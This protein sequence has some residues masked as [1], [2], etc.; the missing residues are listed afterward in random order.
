MDLSLSRSPLFNLQHYFSQKKYTH[1]D[2]ATTFGFQFKRSSNGSSF[3]CP[4]LSYGVRANSAQISGQSKKTAVAPSNKTGGLSG[5][6]QKY[7]AKQVTKTDNRRNSSSRRKKRGEKES[8][9]TGRT[10]YGYWRL[11]NVEIPFEMDPGKDDF[12]LHD[13]LMDAIALALSCRASRL[14]RNAFTLVRKSL[15]ARKEPKFVYTIDIDVKSFMESESDA[16]N[17]LSVLKPAPGKYEFSSF[18]RAAMDI[19]TRLVNTGAIC[20]DA[21]EFDKRSVSENPSKPPSDDSDSSPGRRYQGKRAKVIVVGSGPAGLFAAL[22]LVE[23]GVE[24]TLLERGQP[25]EV[26]G[27]HI[28]ALMARKILNPN[29]NLCYGEG[30]AGTWSD[31]KLTTRIGKNSSSVQTV[32]ATLVRFGAPPQILVDGKPHIGTDKLVRILQNLRHHLESHGAKILFGTKMEDLEITAGRVTGV[33]VSGVDKTSVDC[34]VLEADAVVLGVGHSARDVYEKLISHNVAM[35]AKPFAVGFR[36]EHP[37]ELINELQYHRFASEVQKGK[38]RLPVA[39]YKLAAD[40][41][42]LETEETDAND[43]RSRGCFSFCMCPGGQVVLT[44]T[45]PAELCIN[46][47]SFSRRSSRWANA[48]LVVSVDS[49][50]FSA[51]GYQSGPLAGV[52]FQKGIEQE[53]AIRGGGNFV[54]PVQ[55]VTDFLDDRLSE[56]ALPTS[57]YRLGVR[58]ASLHDLLPSNL[59]NSLKNALLNFERQ[60]PGF[61]DKRG[62][63]HG[64]ETRTSAPVRIE[65]DEESFESISLPGLYPIGEGAGHAGGIVS[66]AV[67]GM[68]V[69]LALSKAFSDNVLLHEV[70]LEA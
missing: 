50:D 26:R 3:I 2:T 44:S 52:A 27:R 32:L 47:M 41:S 13:P 4:H 23:T 10:G 22:T 1:S 55:T 33:R 24:V 21:E 62:L 42:S 9:V 8:A 67:D 28:G 51:F 56:A 15:D 60:L 40:G 14:P 19:V 16:S 36:V 49:S 48:A 12:S 45:N 31:G 58:A 20:S 39:D 18:P 35:T 64:V 34:E 57:S 43:G 5:G 68:R 17:I 63:L 46:G 65:R 29:S 53:A 25:V 7:S 37:Q 59:T 66:A 70:V 38:G 6:R 61:I 11:F 54:V 30:G 69:G